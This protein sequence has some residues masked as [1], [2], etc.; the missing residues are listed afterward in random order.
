MPES[1]LELAT[2][3]SGYSVTSVAAMLA[4]ARSRLDRLSPEQ[5][6]EAAQA[7]ALL[8]DIRSDS[9]REQNGVIPGARFVARNVLEWRCDP[10]S[11]WSDPEVVRDMDRQLIVVCHEGYQSSL[12]AATLQQF[13]FAGATDL[14]GGFLAWRAAGLPVVALQAT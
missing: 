5:A 3:P 7:G 2:A 13:G 4:Q 14:V 6:A 1:K 12:V 10:A 8:I 11:P 9:H